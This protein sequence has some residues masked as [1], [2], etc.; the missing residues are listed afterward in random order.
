MSSRTLAPLQRLKI[1]LPQIRKPLLLAH[2]TCDCTD[3]VQINTN[4]MS[5]GHQ[6]RQL[7]A[8][9]S[10]AAFREPHRARRNKKGSTTFKECQVSPVLQASHATSRNA[11]SARPPQPSTYSMVP[12][13]TSHSCLRLNPP[14]SYLLSTVPGPYN[15]PPFCASSALSSPRPGHHDLRSSKGKHGPVI[16]SQ[17]QSSSTLSQDTETLQ[18]YPPPL[19]YMLNAV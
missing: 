5:L 19:L 10:L 8:L 1:P 7:R 3:S 14:G 6:L 13:P 11:E 15:L 2:W 9:C 12:Y 17:P 4:L 18:V 16:L